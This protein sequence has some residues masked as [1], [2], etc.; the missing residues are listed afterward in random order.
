MAGKVSAERSL[1][2]YFDRLISINDDEA[3]LETAIKNTFTNL[4]RAA[5][6]TWRPA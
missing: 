2:Q 1:Q 6:A 4:E 3:D 5:L